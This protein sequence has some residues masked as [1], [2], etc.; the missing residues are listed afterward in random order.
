L[1]CFFEAK[2]MVVC[3][4]G[5]SENCKGRLLRFEDSVRKEIRGDKPIL[6][7]K[8]VLRKPERIPFGRSNLS[9]Y[10]ALR[11]GRDS[12]EDHWT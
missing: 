8:I 10:P 4:S 6:E 9:R 12:N 7:G 5:L 3:S 1:A 2:I 11:E